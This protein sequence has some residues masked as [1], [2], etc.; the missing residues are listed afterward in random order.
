V[1]AFVIQPVVSWV[2]ALVCAIGGG[3]FGVGLSSAV[4]ASSDPAVVK[5]LA[6][7]CTESASVC[8][9]LSLTTSSPSKYWMFVGAA[10]L[11]VYA[12]GLWKVSQHPSAPSESE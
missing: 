6:K 10:L 8:D 1:P 7:S 9:S 12:V 5:A 2:L 3:V 4:T 11:A